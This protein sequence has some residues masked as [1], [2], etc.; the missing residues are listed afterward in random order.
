MIN[1]RYTAA[2]TLFLLLGFAP[3]MLLSNG[4][5][6][7]AE[8][9]KARAMSDSLKK[10][11]LY[12]ILLPIF[13]TEGTFKKAQEMIPHIKAT[14]INTIYLCPFV[15]YDD[16]TDRGFWSRRQM[17]SG[18]DNPKNPYR[19]K[20]YFNVDPQIGTNDD[21]KAF[22][23]AA[24]KAGLKVIFDLVYF[25]CG[26]KA[27]FIKDNPDFIVRNKDGSVFINNLWYFPELNFKNPKLREYLI[28]NMEYF[29]KELGADGFRMD[30][31]SSVPLDFWEEANIRVSKIKPDLLMLSE[32]HN[33]KEQLKAFDAN[34][35]FGWKTALI[36]VF[37]GK[38][39][40]TQLRKIWTKEFE[41]Y[42]SGAHI[43]RNLDNHDVATDSLT[44]KNGGMRYEKAFGHRGMDAVSVINFC[45]D[46]IPLLFMGNEFADESPVNMFADRNHGRTF[47]AWEN[48]LTKDGQ[49]RM[50]LIKK[51][52]D[53]RVSNAPLWKG[54]TQWI[55]NS[56]PE[57][58]CTFVRDSDGEKI[59]VCVNTSNKKI[60]ADISIDAKLGE[61]LLKYCGEL[62]GGE[63]ILKA[64]FEPYG[65]II[66]KLK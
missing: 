49:D 13:T 61:T 52:S 55:E 44:S 43:L 40:A 57:N 30:V 64:S 47:I 20:D 51:L 10:S 34:Y 22:V 14:G 53:L 33:A 7:Q 18:F 5:A 60:D 11:I 35:S 42:P 31:A 19:I 54:E 3:G 48:L 36:D 58:L 37:Y 39:P 28:S 50:A 8:K 63:K 6:G 25:H 4:N 56:A 17:M 66:T 45:I 15:E 38:K 24:H 59:L 9:P 1:T 46:G 16:D 26:P 41:K 12:Q 29:V 2:I 32:G 23:D 27:V 62:K 21:A 65:W